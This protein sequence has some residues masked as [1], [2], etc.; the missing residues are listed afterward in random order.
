MNDV[1]GAIRKLILGNKPEFALILAKEFNTDSVDH[2]L[3]LLFSHT[4]H[5]E[6]MSITNAILDQ[7][8]NNTLKN[9]L[10]ASYLNNQQQADGEIRTVRN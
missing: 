7:I 9:I 3:T 8:K 1:N 5:F 4:V 2:V 10:E 6:Q